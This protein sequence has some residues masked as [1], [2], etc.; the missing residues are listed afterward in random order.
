MKNLVLLAAIGTMALGACGS[1]GNPGPSLIDSG[2]GPDAPPAAPTCNPVTKTG[3]ETGE[4]CARLVIRDE[5]AEGGV[6]LGQIACVPDG[7]VTEGAACAYGEDGQTTG[8]DNCVAGYDCFQGICTEICAGNP[9]SCRAADEE[10]GTGFS[11]AVNFENHFDDTI[12]TCLAACNPVDD[13]ALEGV[14][15]NATCGAGSSCGLN[16]IDATTSCAGTPG[17]AA[18][19]T[20]NEV[21]Y[22]PGGG[23][24]YS[25]GCASGFAAGLLN[26]NLGADSG[27]PYCARYCTPDN[28]YLDAQGAI[29]G[30]PNGQRNQCG[31]T[32][33]EAVG[34]ASSVAGKEYNCR[35][36]QQLFMNTNLV[37]EVVGI[38]SPIRA[39]GGQV[40][41]TNGAKGEL[42][43]RGSCVKYELDGL[44]A[45]WNAAAPNGADAA[46]AAL[47]AFCLSDAE[48][49]MTA[50]INASCMGFFAACTSIEF[51]NSKLD[52]PAGGGGGAA[53]LTRDF[54]NKYQVLLPA[55]QAA[56]D[57]LGL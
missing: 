49:P 6:F 22:G 19:Q 42:G 36:I 10:F 23:A 24:I 31:A 48:N 16:S 52:D 2:V 41:L 44:A 38:C 17:P 34:T 28:T 30:N 40:A 50:S 4:K 26:E 46:N 27:E 45:A 5:T 51:E 37:P 25:N 43:L 9:D 12:G 21:P 55:S 29:V 14:A 7:D 53:Q 47:L 8:F 35:F 18:T 33:L 15:V 57:E 13:T 54:R 39:E 1:D 3:C 11:C 32:E 20:Q 56:I